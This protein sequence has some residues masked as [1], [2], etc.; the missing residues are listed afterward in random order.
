MI[1]VDHYVRN[2]YERLSFIIMSYLS[3]VT[4]AAAAA[5]EDVG[6]VFFTHL[7]LLNPAVI[8]G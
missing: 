2:D 3:A 4:Y 6:P 1:S 5:D 7:K 8:L